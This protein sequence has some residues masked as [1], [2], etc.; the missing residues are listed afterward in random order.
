MLTQLLPELKVNDIIF[1]DQFSVYLHEY[2]A[3]KDATAAYPRQFILLCRT[4]D[5]DRVAMKAI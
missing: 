2:R 3:F 4:G 1:F 5:W